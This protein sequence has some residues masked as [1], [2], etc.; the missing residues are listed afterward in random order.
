MEEPPIAGGRWP[1]GVPRYVDAS[2]LVFEGSV[3]T[4]EYR[5]FKL[6]CKW[7]EACVK[8]RAGGLGRRRHL[9]RLEPVAYVAVWQSLGATAGCPDAKAHKAPAVAPRI[10]VEAQPLWLA[11][12]GYAA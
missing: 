7:H 9:G 3:A 10:T 6:R 11:E 12:S 2:P 1:D 8:T 5:R 4:L